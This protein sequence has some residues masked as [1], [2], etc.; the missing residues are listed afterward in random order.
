MLQLNCHPHPV[1]RGRR[2]V[3][4][5]VRHRTSFFHRRL[6]GRRRRRY[7]RCHRDPSRDNKPAAVPSALPL[8]IDAA[9][10]LSGR[11]M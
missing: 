6:L 11:S 10:W 1:R 5:P 8:F 3:R 9:Y 4:R 7:H 2:P